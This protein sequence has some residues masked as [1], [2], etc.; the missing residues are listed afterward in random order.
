[1]KLFRHVFR[2]RSLAGLCGLSTLMSP[3]CLEREGTPGGD[4]PGFAPDIERILSRFCF[5]CHGK[6]H[7][8]AELDLRTREAIL[9]G[10]ESGPA[11]VPG[12]PEESLL[13]DMIHD[14][15]MPPEGELLKESEIDQ[16]RRWIAA[17]ARP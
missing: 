14:E 13:L 4:S 11:I 10:G 5:E 8:E 3:G 9:A 6:K 2:A 7:Q 15:H 16:V 17:G 12:H 1:M